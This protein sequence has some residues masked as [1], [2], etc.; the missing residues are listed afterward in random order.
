MPNPSEAN[1]CI[2]VHQGGYSYQ[3][4]KTIFKEADALGFH[5]ASLYDLITYPTLECWTTLSALSAE[6]E[7]IRLVPLVLAN[8]YR[9]P[10]LL[11]N[12]AATLD[13]ISNGRLTI[14]IGAGGGEGDHIAVGL[15]YPSAQK[16]VAMLEEAVQIMK[17][18]WTQ[19]AVT[20]EG[21]H[22]QIRDAKCDP[23]PVQDPHPPF[24]IGGHGETHLLRALAAHGDI[25]NMRSDMS[26]QDHTQKRNVIQKHC[27][28]VGRNISDITISHN[29]RVFIAEDEPSLEA[30]LSEHAASHGQSTEQFKES[31]GNAIYGTPDQCA[32]KIQNYIDYGI[33]YF[34]LLFPDPIDVKLLRLFA[35][36]VTPLLR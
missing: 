4:I 8:L 36:Q 32:A 10:V 23:K 14:G 9:N 16:R 28:S 22:Y 21:Q 11:A 19:D 18:L 7:Q 5:S 12:M 13:V 3:S 35:E 30:M 29:T 25:A 26:L 1:F 31:L 20:F 17:A 27:D 15:P 33:N 6:T 2:R 24:L 34:F